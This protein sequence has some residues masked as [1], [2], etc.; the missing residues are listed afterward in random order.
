MVDSAIQL[1][2]NWGLVIEVTVSTNLLAIITISS[3]LRLSLKALVPFRID[4]VTVFNA[5]LT[6]R[7]MCEKLQCLYENLLS[8]N[9]R[10]TAVLKKICL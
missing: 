3:L 4:L 7:Q 6:S 5:I 9:F 10:R 1:L 8:N 2:N